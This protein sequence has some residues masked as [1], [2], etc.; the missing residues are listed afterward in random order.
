MEEQLE[1]NAGNPK[2]RQADAREAAKAIDAAA[3]KGFSALFEEDRTATLRDLGVLQAKQ[4]QSP[5]VCA[6]A[7]ADGQSAVLAMRDDEGRLLLLESTDAVNVRGCMIPQPYC[8]RY[9]TTPVTSLHASTVALDS[10][11]PDVGSEVMA[12]YPSTDSLYKATVES[13][14]VDLEEPDLRK[15]LG[16]TSSPVMQTAVLALSKQ[17][18]VVVTF[19]GDGGRRTVVP[20][21]RMYAV[22]AEGGGGSSSSSSST[23]AGG[24]DGD[25]DMDMDGACLTSASAMWAFSRSVQR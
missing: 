24:A 12:L 5:L 3:S 13:S 17:P 14:V 7:S 19:E 18:C 10:S 16:S 8:F 2:Y 4:L 21:R 6:V 1:Q 22:A 23:S 9:K 25:S 15:K 11:V 20:V